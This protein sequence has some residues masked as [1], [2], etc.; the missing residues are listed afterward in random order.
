MDA[1]LPAPGVTQRYG[2]GTPTMR[3]RRR[4]AAP[5][6]HDH[7]HPG[8]AG[9]VN[10]VALSADGR[11]HQHRRHGAPV[12]HYHRHRPDGNGRPHRNVNGIAPSADGRLAS[13]AGD[14]GT[15]R[16]WDTRDAVIRTAIYLGGAINSVSLATGLNYASSGPRV[17]FLKIVERFH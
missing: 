10:G 2:C 13:G 5:V 15:V 14:D 3:Q 12:G 8:R 17:L 1:W 9:N 4:H 7:Y 6:G 11:L 16:L